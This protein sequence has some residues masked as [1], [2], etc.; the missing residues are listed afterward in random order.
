MSNPLKHTWLLRWKIAAKY[1]FKHGLS[2]KQALNIA[3]GII[4][5]ANYI[6]SRNIQVDG[7]W[8]VG[9]MDQ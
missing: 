8:L 7:G 6:R 9:R 5:M 1:V 4:E 3:D 2:P